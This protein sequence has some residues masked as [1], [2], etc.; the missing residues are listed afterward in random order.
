MKPD[1]HELFA[2]LPGDAVVQRRPAGID[3]WTNLTIE[4]SAGPAG[5]RHV[6]V[7]LADGKPVSATDWVMFRSHSA[8]GTTCVHENVGGRLEPDGRF[9][10]TRW[11]T[12]A[13]ERP[14]VEEAEMR[15]MTRLPPSE[16]DIEAIRALVLDVLRLSSR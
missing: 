6:M 11:R 9:L 8:E 4:L 13:F 10:G 5:L 2:P 1:W 14:G 3:G 12:V 15:E 16:S 7:T